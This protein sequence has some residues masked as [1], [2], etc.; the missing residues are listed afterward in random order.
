MI[1]DSDKLKLIDFGLAKVAKQP[2]LH[3]VAGTPYY[4]APEIVSGDAYGVKADMWSIGVLL[5]TMMC[6]YLPFNGKTTERV[7]E[8]IKVGKINFDH[9]EFKSV[10]KEGK[11]LI[12]K[13]LVV[14]PRKRITAQELLN[15]AWI[16]KFDE[17]T[18]VDA[19]TDALD[20][21]A[22]ENMRKFKGVSHLKRA[23]MNILVKMA[24]EQ[25]VAELTKTFQRIDT[26]NS[27]SISIEELLKLV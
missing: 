22:I 14:D 20:K 8:R 13:L 23:V 12:K 3:Q 7:F 2:S 24:S 10:S 21:K 6:G 15:D 9:E 26:D 11:E 27:G 25:E 5:Y 4:M 18:I 19:Q 1:T 16:K 17:G